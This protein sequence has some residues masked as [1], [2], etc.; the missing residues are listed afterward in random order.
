MHVIESVF[1]Q[2]ERHT[3]ARILVRSGAVSDGKHVAPNV[4]NMFFRVVWR[5]PDRT[6]RLDVRFLPRIRCSRI[7]DRNIFTAVQPACDF[8]SRYLCHFP[9]CPPDWPPPGWPPPF[10]RPPLL[11][12]LPPLFQSPSPGWDPAFWPLPDESACCRSS[13]FDFVPM[14]LFN[15]SDGP[16]HR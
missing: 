15:F 1:F 3:G 8:I 16:Q 11:A 2:S 14:I 10:I 4:R 7:D 12:D 6:A 13:F 9:P 5:D